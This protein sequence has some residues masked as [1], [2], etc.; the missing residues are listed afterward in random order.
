MA[1][2]LHKLSSF[3]AFLCL[4]LLLSSPNDNVEARLCRSRNR[5]FSGI[6]T[7]S[8][9]GDSVCRSHGAVSGSCHADGLGFACFC[10]NNCKK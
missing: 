5:D 6:C 9:H 2:S 8:G 4:A 3:I 10:D 1:A 7:D